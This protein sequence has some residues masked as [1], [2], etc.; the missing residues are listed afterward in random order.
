MRRVG[1]RYTTVGEM[2]L[3][4]IRQAIQIGVLGPGERIRQDSL[5]QAIGVSRMPV[6]SA[7]MQLESEGLVIFY[8]HRGAVVRPLAKEQM[9]EL[10]EIRR[11]LESYALERAVATMT[12]E[13]LVRLEK[14]AKQLDKATTG[15]KFGEYSMRF[16][17]EL[18]DAENNP[19]LVDIVE[20]VHRDIGRFWF[21][22]RVIDAHKP[23][24][25]ELLEPCRR[26]DV[27]Q[28]KA[29]LSEHLDKVGRELE[30]LDWQVVT[31]SK[32]GSA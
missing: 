8:P 9:R 16:Y 22:Q 28:A 4:V 18:Y 20:R 25:Q 5:A 32:K 7:L 12:P 6:R 29:W 17:R 27:A 2:V 15:A 13:R 23:V 19:M 10:Y 21:Q 24:H 26:G 31:R 3:E 11:V 1:T 14:L 30:T